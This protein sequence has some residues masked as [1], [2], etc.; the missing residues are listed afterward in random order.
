MMHRDCNRGSHSCAQ[1]QL[2]CFTQLA[3][4]IIMDKGS[5]AKA[6]RKLNLANLLALKHLEV[7]SQSV[8]GFERGRY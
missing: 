1:T 4:K 3:E 6:Y 5:S 2:S 8:F 7:V